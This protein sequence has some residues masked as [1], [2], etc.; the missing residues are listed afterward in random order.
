MRKN[1]CWFL[2]KMNVRDPLKWRITRQNLCSMGP[3]QDS[4]GLRLD[5]VEFL[6]RFPNVGGFDVGVS[7]NK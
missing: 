1:T 7:I 5:R 2:N 6:E 3:N 4:H